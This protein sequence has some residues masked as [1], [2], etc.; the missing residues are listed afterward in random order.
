VS[1]PTSISIPKLRADVSGR[2]IGPGDAEYD[3]ARAVFYGGFD[4]HP[5]AVVRV[6]DE[7]D[8]TRVIALA[9]ETGLEL[10]VRSGGHSV[11][12][13]GVSDGGIVIDLADLRSIEV[14]PG[15][16]TAWAQT[17]LTALEFTNAT[18][19]HGLGSGGSRSAAGWGTSSEGTA[20]RSTAC[21]PPRS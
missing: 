17:G 10:A 21:W 20:S 11:I 7:M 3:Q 6:A 15:E 12:G 9:R 16:R 19:A 1:T 18:H 14:D 4:L 13:Q 2:V 8:I 5:A